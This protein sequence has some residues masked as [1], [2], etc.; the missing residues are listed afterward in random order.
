MRRLHALVLAAAL[1]A[2]SHSTAIPEN[3]YGLEVIESRRLYQRIARNDP[4]QVLV[5][6]NALDPSIAL[7]VRYAT[8]ENFMKT[9]LYPAAEA[10]ARCDVARALARVQAS[11]RPRGVGLKVFDAY[12]PYSVTVAM[13]EPY[14]D[15]DYVADPKKGSRH[16]RGA[17]VDVTLI[18]LATGEELPMPTGYDDFTPKAHHDATDLPLEALQNRAI[19][20]QAMEAGGFEALPSEW[21]HYDYRGWASYPL[22]DIPHRELSPAPAECS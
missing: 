18:D 16:N 19:L 13:W 6:V 7:D 1:S 8:D 5:A 3:E 21:W 22:M 4:Q 14:Q 10:W 2:C 9:R 11:L 17:A 20:R 12:R 15:P